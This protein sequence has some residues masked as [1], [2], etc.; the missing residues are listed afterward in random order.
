[1]NRP[2]FGI[3]VGRF[4]VHELHDGHMELFRIVRGRHSRILVFLGCNNVGPTRHDPL[5]FE[6]RKKMIQAKFPEFTVL[7]LRDK[8]TDEQW[9]NEL[10]ARIDDVTGGVPAEVR[11]YGSRESFSP[12][13]HGKHHVHELDIEV[14][15][16]LSGT[17]IRKKLTNEVMEDPKFRAGIIYAMSQLFPRVITCVDIAI[18]HIM[19]IDL[20]PGRNK[21]LIHLLLGQKPEDTGWRFIGG[22]ALPITISFEV[23]AKKEAMEETGL[24]VSDL[25]Y[26][27][28]SLIDCWRWKAEKSENMKTVFYIAKSMTMGGAANDDISRVRWFKLSDLSEEIIEREHRPLFKMLVSHIHHKWGISLLKDEGNKRISRRAIEA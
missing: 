13:Y 11:L 15:V 9:S 1:M 17:D 26:V 8:K 12:F 19:G 24:D 14:P 6:T 27:G 28:S 21:E 23:D 18:V 7:P 16:A 20:F 4:Q 10:D 3:V 25:E 22:H 2:S 5:D